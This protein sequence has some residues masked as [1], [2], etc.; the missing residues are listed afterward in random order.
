MKQS[1][2]KALEEEARKAGAADTRW[3]NVASIPK[4]VWTRMKCQFGCEQYGKCLCCPPYIPSLSDME[5]FLNEYTTG[6]LV[7]YTISVTEEKCRNWKS[8]DR[9]INNDLLRLVVR[10]E[11]AA[12]MKNY[13]KAFALKAGRCALCEVCNLKHCV[14]PDLAR[15]SME[16][17][18]IDV[19][20]LA[21][22]NGFDTR[23]YTGAVKEI[24]VYGLVLL[25]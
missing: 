5:R 22:E 16:A 8:V 14:H 17:C 2:Q 12:M 25:E 7:K 1:D 9:K 21:K 23:M 4:G 13:Y 24:S 6:L 10:I 19:F 20:A 15:P 18:G 3:I 11:R